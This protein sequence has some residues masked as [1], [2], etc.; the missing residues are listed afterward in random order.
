MNSDDLGCLS[1]R[2]IDSSRKTKG[3][4]ECMSAGLESESLLTCLV[5][6][7]SLH[8]H[9]SDSLKYAV[10][11]LNAA[12]SLVYYIEEVNKLWEYLF[13]SAGKWCP[14]GPAQSFVVF[15]LL[16]EYFLVTP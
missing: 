5:V 8:L 4:G 6:Y 2:F 10:L 7:L 11:V 16:L 13:L 14:F 15:S 3:Y 9:F 1:F 12:I